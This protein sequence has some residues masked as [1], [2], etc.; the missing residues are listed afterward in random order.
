[1]LSCRRAVDL[2]SEQNM[3][4]RQSSQPRGKHSTTHPGVPR[5]RAVV[6]SSVR[7]LFGYQKTELVCLFAGRR[8]VCTVVPS[9][10]RLVDPPSCH[11]VVSASFIVPPYCE[12]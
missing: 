9:T 3:I 1:M 10:R 8:R 2:S 7:V 6:D 12:M 5:R 11:R 4:F